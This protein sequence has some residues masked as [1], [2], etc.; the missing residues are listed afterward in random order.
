MS[1]KQ[2][3]NIMKCQVINIRQENLRKLGYK[4]LEEWLKNPNHIYIGRNM[5][6]YI[7]GAYES[8]WKNPFK[9]KEH[10]NKCLE[11]YKYYIQKNPELLEQLDELEGKVLGC[12][13]KPASCHGDILKEL[14]ER[15][16]K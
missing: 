13:C 3:K 5:S 15:R 11:L 14:L 2:E 12:F 9:V 7:K 16:S 10:G 8:K 6:F 4:N 1:R